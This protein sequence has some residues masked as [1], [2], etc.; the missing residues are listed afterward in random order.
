[1]LNIIANLYKS[2]YKN[3]GRPIDDFEIKK[4]IIGRSL[5]GVDVMDWAVHVAELRLWLQ[6]IVESELPASEIQMKP[7]LPNL[8]FKV[9]QGDSLVE[10]IGG[11]NLSLRQDKSLS[12]TIKRKITQLKQEKLKFYNNDPSRK[13][14]TESLLLHEELNIFQDLL[15]EKIHN[16]HNQLVNLRNSLYSL[17]EQGR[18]IAPNELQ[19]KEQEKMELYNKDALRN[20][21]E[22]L[23]KEEEKLKDIRKKSQFRNKAIC[24]GHRLCR[25]IF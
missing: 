3:L 6:L 2:T 13:F 12:P 25:N 17:K 18:L 21:I 24:L 4:Q 22:R 8:T 5:Y 16:L 15:D 10:E 1:M 11:I 9:K 7:L 14:K 19:V 23:E 20:E